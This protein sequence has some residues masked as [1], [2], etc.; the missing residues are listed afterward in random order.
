[1]VVQVIAVPEIIDIHIIVLVPVVAPVFWPGV[2]DT[3]P[4]AAVLEAGIPANNCQREAVDAEPVILTK[5]TPITVPRNTIAFVAA[6]LLPGAVLG[7][8][9]T[10]AMLLPNPALF[11]LLH[12]LRLM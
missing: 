6:A 11:T 1:M 4:K 7:L 3:E 2:N 12:T 5:V 9:A 10:C 8:P